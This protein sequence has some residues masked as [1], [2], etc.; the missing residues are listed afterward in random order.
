MKMKYNFSIVIPTKNEEKNIKACMESIFSQKQKQIEILI[1]DA[2]SSDNTVKY[3][4]D[5][6]NRNRKDISIKIIQKK[7]PAEKAIAYG[8]HESKGDIISFLGADDRLYNKNTLSNVSKIFKTNNEKILYGSYLIIDEEDRPIKKV[9]SK[10]FNRDDLLNDGNYI[11]AT[12]LFFKKSIFQIIKKNIDDGYD[13]AFILKSSKYLKYLRTKKI[14]SKFKIHP[15]SNS[16]N[17]YKN[18]LNIKKDYIISKKYGGR[19]YNNY[20]RRYLLIKTLDLFNLLWLGELKRKISMSKLLGRNIDFK[21]KS[22]DVQERIKQK[23]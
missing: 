21:R 2:F 20:H 8:I 5:Y 12:S 22:L 23:V 19:K 7:L 13:F 1:I 4:K 17:F 18:I 11:C 10:K 15:M 9:I 6:R 16:G 3:L 14:L